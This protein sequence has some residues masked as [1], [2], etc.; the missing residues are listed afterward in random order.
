M[1]AI[2]RRRRTRSL[3]ALGLAVILIA[4]AGVLVGVAVGTLRNS[5]A[6]EAVGIDERPVSYLPSTPNALLAV[7]G[8]D[9]ELTSIVVTTLLPSGRGGTIVTMPVNADM[10]SGVGDEAMPLGAHGSR[11]LIRFVDGIVRE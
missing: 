8:D 10:N 6:G 4:T 3:I 9:G 11:E 1:T 7:V 2:P 5:Q